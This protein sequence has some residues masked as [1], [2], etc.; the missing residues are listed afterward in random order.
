MRAGLSLRL[1]GTSDLHANIF[2]Y[3]YYRDRPD[4]TVGLAKAASL[5]AAARAEVANA[6]LFDNGD[7]IQGAPLADYAA[8]AM[9]LKRG[10]V[11]PMIAAMN[12]LGYAACS[13][14]NHDFNYGLDFLDLALAG[15]A[16][17]A[18]SCNVLRPDG[19]PYFTPWLVLEP[20]LR[21]EAGVERRLRIGVIGFT[22]PQIVQW[23]QSLLQGRVTT[24]GIAEA[25]RIRLPEL[26][27]QGVD[28]VIALCH[29][30]ITHRTP[31]EAD[32]EN[33]AL[34]LAEVG[35]VDAIF[36]GHQ[37]LLLPGSDFAG[38]AGVDAVKGA[39]HGVPACMPG[40]WGSH[41]GVID[42]ALEPTQ[43][44]WRIASAK[45]E[46]RP[47][48][49]RD[50][51]AVI[52]LAEADP[53][54]LAAAAD[55]HQATLT[56]VR[57]PVGDI[58]S[59]LTSYFAVVADDPSVAI[60]NAAQRWYLERLAPTLPALNG[61]PILSAAAPFKSGGR[62]GPDFYTEVPA[63]PIAIKHVADLY[64][65]PNALRVV[66][67]DGATL[68][69]WLERSAAL[70]LRIDPELTAEQP[71]IDPAFPGYDFDVVD[72]VTYEIDVTV[73]SRYDADGALVAPSAR[74]IRDLAF[75][76]APVDP[77]QEF[78]VVT[79]SYRAGGGGN[80]PGCDGSTIVFEAPDANRD[81]L[82]RY[83]SEMR[84]IEPKPGGSWRFARWPGHVVASFLTS[85]AA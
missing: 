79:N 31:P 50:G 28:L 74:R 44:S 67:I 22:P 61:L 1:I 30:G 2:A 39:L 46:A 13:I 40:F 19:R 78:L 41:I 63:G 36:L 42:L 83:I 73:P 66:K 6:L 47:I 62:G 14:G 65:Y 18:L 32:E 80:F 24:V 82:V 81:A 20:A 68:A 72:G 69:E 71:L 34:T 29:S 77:R 52:P 56:Y 48:Y 3:D 23:D 59:P 43:A 60:V 17:P 55:A 70:F 9:G 5:I 49:R 85:P 38:I 54:V 84:H 37:H 25:A 10:D 35:G 8:T 58:A 57:L 21:D 45:V 53:A 11:H 33:A 16:F 12:A 7:I 15:A 75:R 4:D 51:E 26:R 76:G 64:P 27:A